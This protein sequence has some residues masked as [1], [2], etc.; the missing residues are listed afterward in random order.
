MEE[1][2]RQLDGEPA[3]VGAGASSGDDHDGGAMA[4]APKD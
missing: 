3:L 2:I 4:S 1:K